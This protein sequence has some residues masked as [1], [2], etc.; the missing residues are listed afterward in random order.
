MVRF[1][2]FFFFFNVQGLLVLVLLMLGRFKLNDWL[3]V[4]TSLE[5]ELLCTLPNSFCFNLFSAILI[6]NINLW[7]YVQL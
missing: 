2:F 3:E 7:I 5:C 6:I 1:F 4:K